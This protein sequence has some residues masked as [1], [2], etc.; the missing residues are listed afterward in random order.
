MK[1]FNEKI[2]EFEQGGLSYVGLT[3]VII[4]HNTTHDE[5]FIINTNGIVKQV[6]LLKGKIYTQFHTKFGVK[7]K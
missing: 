7:V 1:F 6:N 5:Q 4:Q 3:K 2:A